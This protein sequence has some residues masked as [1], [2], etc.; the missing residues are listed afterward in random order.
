MIICDTREQKLL[1]DPL[2]FNVIKKKL[3]EGDYT[4]EELYNKAHIERKSGIDL[5]GSII[6]GHAR[7]RKEIM[8]AKEKNIKFAIFVECPEETFYRKRFAGGY[9]LQCSSNQLRSVLGTMK[10]KYSLEIVWCE[11]RDDMR[12]KM[13]LW[14]VKR[15]SELNNG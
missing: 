11:D 10:E 9:R 2:K 6:Q 5:Y 13:C 4:T 15:Q 3:D 7:F 1:W 8:R 14:F 12:D